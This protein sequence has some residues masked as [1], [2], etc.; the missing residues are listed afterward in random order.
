MGRT[1]LS[2]GC[3]FDEVYTFRF[4]V[5][6]TTAHFKVTTHAWLRLMLKY[7]VFLLQSAD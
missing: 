7:S 2:E 4:V 5:L 6:C 3:Y 1:G